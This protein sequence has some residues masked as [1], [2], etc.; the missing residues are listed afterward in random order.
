MS[1]Q[2]QGDSPIA[3]SRG[4]NQRLTPALPGLP[5]DVEKQDG[6]RLWRTNRIRNQA[7]PRYTKNQSLQRFHI[8]APKSGSATSVRYEH[9]KPADLTF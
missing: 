7:N 6:L 3:A 5:A 1:T 8:R 4:I 2:I 9:L